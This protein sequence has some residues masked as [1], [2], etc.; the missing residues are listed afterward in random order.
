MNT[1]EEEEEEE[2]VVDAAT[3]LRGALRCAWVGVLVPAAAAVFL[4]DLSF[5]LPCTTVLYADIRNFC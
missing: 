2:E 3:P 4:A 5:S 1:H